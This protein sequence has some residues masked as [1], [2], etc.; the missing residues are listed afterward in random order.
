MH[1]SLFPPPSYPTPILE[2]RKLDCEETRLWI[3][4]DGLA[5]PV[6]GGNKVRK[7]QRIV[8][9]AERKKARRILTFGAAGSHHVLT[10]ALFARASGLGA[11]AIMTSQPTSREVIETLRASLGQGV[12][13]YPAQTALDVPSAFRRAW[14][15]TDFVVP[16]GGSSVAGVLGYVDAVGELTRQVREKLL[17]EPDLIVVT[18]GSGGTC[19]GILAG[20]TLHGLASRVLGVLVLKNPL[21]RWLVLGLA[22]RALTALSWRVKLSD[23]SGRLQI[24]ARYVGTGYGQTTWEGEEAMA[25]A[26]SEL[27]LTLDR[28]YTAKG[29]AATLGLIRSSRRRYRRVLY[30]HTLSCAPFEPLLVSAPPLEALLPEVRALLTGDGDPH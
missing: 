3:K 18:L 21:A 24:D 17:P 1:P 27:N 25:I 10:T 20:V 6:Y 15:R 8:R 29:F 19:A 22:H 4:N 28:T 26:Q 7:L 14:K 13:L 2:G 9:E 12:E 5:H 30:W 16:P 23:L 11:A